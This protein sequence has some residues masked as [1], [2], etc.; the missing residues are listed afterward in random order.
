M[1]FKGGRMMKAQLHWKMAIIWPFAD[2][3]HSIRPS[4]GGGVGGVGWGHAPCGDSHD[5]QA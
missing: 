2:T 1:L 5:F 3:C 4:V